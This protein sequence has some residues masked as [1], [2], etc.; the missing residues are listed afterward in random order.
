MRFCVDVM[1]QPW[2]GTQTAVSRTPDKV[3]LY[4]E[5]KMHI[6]TVEQ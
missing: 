1:L 6:L 2:P 4:A 3:S 5:G